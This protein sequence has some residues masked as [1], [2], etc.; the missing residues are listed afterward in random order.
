MPNFG[1]RSK[2]LRQYLCLDLR[3]LVDEVIK[4]YDFSIVET[5]RE[6]SEQEKAYYAKRSKAHFG[7]SAH[8]Y[9]P[10]FAVDV[11][12][13]PVPQK[14]VNGVIV[15]DDNSPRWAEMINLFKAIAQEMGIDIV[16][17]IDFK[18]FRDAPHI[19]IA[20]WKQRVRSI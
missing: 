7:Q 2:E 13:Y 4:H 14:D 15:I 6:K 5:Y 10:A 20:D 11:Y 12:P 3:L 18:S 16:C 1:R 17:G 19:E 8:N 9:H